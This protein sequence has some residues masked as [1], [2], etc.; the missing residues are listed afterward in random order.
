[1]SWSFNF[2]VH[3]VL[4]GLT[5]SVVVASFIL[6][7]QIIT[8]K[9]WEKKHLLS[10]L[11]RI[12]SRFVPFNAVLLLVTGFGNMM[13]RYG[14]NAQWPSEEWL[15]IKVV[16]FVILAANGLYLA[17]HLGLKRNMLI[18]SV[19]EGSGPADADQQIVKQNFSITALFIVQ[20]I[21][22]LSILF[23]SVYGSGK[24]PGMF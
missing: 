1:M 23:L 24:H 15:S 21:L 5:T 13:N 12:F 3:I 22:L 6:H 9:S 10:G 18:K 7:R 4:F 16:L 11:I 20:M 14:T 8:E 17:P 19:I 2:F